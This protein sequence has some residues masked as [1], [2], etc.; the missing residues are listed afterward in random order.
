MN[1]IEMQEI[2]VKL[3]NLTPILLSLWRTFSWMES[4]I[5]LYHE[6]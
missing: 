4:A 3:F 6:H 2:G 5:F 1:D